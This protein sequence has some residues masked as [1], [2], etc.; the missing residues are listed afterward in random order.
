MR[1][2]LIK[3]SVG[4]ISL[5]LF[6][7]D[8]FSQNFTSTDY[9][10]ALWMT[11]RMY[12]GQ[13]S[14]ANNWL[15]YNHLPSGVNASLTG[16]AF[17]N[18]QDTDGYDLSGGWHDCGDHVKF[19]QT[20]FYSAYMLLKAYYEFPTGYDDY[21]SYDY[22]GYKAGNDWSWEG[23]KH[24][25]NG[26][27]DIVDEVKHAT[28]Y[29]IKCTRNSTTFYYQVGQGDPDHALWVTAVK[30]QTVA[31]ASGGDIRTVYK[32]PAD[33]SMASFC[34]AT[35]ALMSKIYRKFD[36]AYADLCLVH[37][38][39][40]YDYAKAHPGV[41]GAGDGGFYGANDNWKD[42][43][44]DMCAELFWATGNVVYKNEALAFSIAS[45]P[46]QGGDIYGKGYGFDYSNNGDIAIYNLA[47]LGKT[48]AQSTLD[49]IVK[50]YY[51]GNVQPDG[52]FAGGNTGWG[53]LRYN[54]NS[55]LIVAFWQKLYGTTATPHKFIYDNIDYILG[56]NA[57][58]QS[59]IVGFGTKPVKYPHHRNVY[60]R[61]D[62]PSDAV[63]R[64]LTIPIKN[65]QFGLMVGGT[66][67]PGTYSD[68]LVN[69]QH[70]EGGLDYNACLVGVLAFINS[71]LAPVDTGKF[72]NPTPDLGPS[73]SICGLTQIILDSKIPADGKKTYTWLKDGAI[74]QA[75]S[76]SAKTYKVTQAGKY[77][78]KLDSAGKWSTSSSV[79]ILGILPDVALGATQE[80][81]SPAFVTLNATATGSGITYQWSKNGSIIKNATSISY[82]IYTAGT[83]RA[84]IN[85]TGCQ[86]KYG[87]VVITSKLPA[88]R[89][90]TLCKA[91]QASL[92]ILGAG[93]PFEWYDV[94]TGGTLLSTGAN[95]N[96]TISASKTYYV[97]DASS[98]SVT[99]GPSSTN[100][101]L[102]G[103]QNG[104]AVGIR[105]IAAKSFNITQMK[106]LPYV[107]SCNATDKVS[108]QVQLKQNGTILAT[109]TSDA[110][111]CA[112]TQSGTPFNTFYTINF[113]VPIN[114]P[115]SGNYELIPT[116]TGNTV[117]W[118]GSGANF[119]SFD[120]V[121]VMDITDDTRDD[122]AN[123]FPGIFDIKLQA[124]ST[125]D[126]IP[127]FA[128]IDQNRPC[129]ITTGFEEELTVEQELSV[130]PNPS[131]HGFTLKAKP[132]I[133][134]RVYDELGRI[135]KDI[136]A[137]DNQIFGAD[138]VAGI[139][140]V[141]IYENGK[142]LKTINI[143]KE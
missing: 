35:L 94:I 59:F 8:S 14:G 103:P 139:Y 82:T 85:A 108:F 4:I 46:G 52:Q 34:G 138:F 119:T 5:F 81:C 136:N 137:G 74:V 91:G 87:E 118:F 77:T 100:N 28:D 33:A 21:Y 32:N 130:Y 56:K 135:V 10:K 44:A 79:D 113:A 84:I 18:D 96:P 65:Q 112:G 64:T 30:M 142:R 2:I 122:A 86:S 73:Q 106:I 123:S 27:P 115:S 71:K 25:P 54:A 23:A 37:A 89:N 16:M 61:D 55:A 88:V 93:G 125:C 141:I 107:Y 47:L 62:N 24:D 45:A 22:K 31:K 127:V 13:R 67:T 105:F 134:S 38:K 76:T 92:A 26:I 69:Y 53:P 63:K 109:Y 48:N 116:T 97:K 80:L 66:R 58:N 75:A 41:V 68:D 39:Y 132:G 117:A 40:A 128:L 90:D 131:S 104:G 43:Y 129:P 11:T 3:I 110:V 49:A 126:R 101:P 12:G 120:A 7:I 98:V 57:N 121:G 19:G 95:Y 6:S 114:V 36:P 143:V 1:A 78:C 102:S 20:E 124:G 111:A 72:G 60:L 99:A 133:S 42:D 17:I 50:N 9:K 29:F 51:L 140:H 70:T 83:Y 15:L